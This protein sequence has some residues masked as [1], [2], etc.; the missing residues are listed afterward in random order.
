M[1]ERGKDR[2]LKE[3]Y[4]HAPDVYCSPSILAPQSFLLDPHAST[5]APSVAPLDLPNTM[6][7]ALVC[8]TL[9]TVT[10]T[11]SPT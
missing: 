11:V 4:L 8:N 9:D 3:Q 6:R 1:K 7:P 10:R 5:F 2:G